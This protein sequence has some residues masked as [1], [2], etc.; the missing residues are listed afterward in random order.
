[1]QEIRGKTTG[2]IVEILKGGTIVRV[3]DKHRNLT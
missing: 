3:E 1:M 2:E